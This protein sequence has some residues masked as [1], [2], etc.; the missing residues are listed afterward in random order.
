MAFTIH[1]LS[2]HCRSLIGLASLMTLAYQSH[3]VKS[4]KFGQNLDELA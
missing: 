3:R 2:K 1:M 4:I